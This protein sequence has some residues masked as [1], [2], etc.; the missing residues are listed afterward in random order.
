MMPKRELYY[1]PKGKGRH[2]VVKYS[3][4]YDFQQWAKSEFPTSNQT[5]WRSNAWVI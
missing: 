2:K 1:P 3:S 4:V 5:L